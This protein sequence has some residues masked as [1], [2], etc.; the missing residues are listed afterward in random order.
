MNTVTWRDLLSRRFDTRDQAP[1]TTW[2][3]QRLGSVAAALAFRVGLSPNAV[4]LCGL[5]SMLAAALVYALGGSAGAWVLAAVLWQLGF[6]LD[7]ADGQLARAT[8]R[9]SAYGAWLDVACDHV[10]QSAI[11]LAVL[12]VL[13]TAGLPIG[14]AY[15]AVFAMLSG[16]TVYLHTAS[17]MKAEAPPAIRVG[18]W[19]TLVRQ[20]LRALLDTPFFLLLLCALRPQPSLLAL[21]AL[22]YGG[23]LVVRAL[24]I[25]ALRLQG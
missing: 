10:R 6:A 2:V 7:C 11:A 15:G 21:F 14:L 19:R 20:L 16:M 9:G 23:L 5:V 22:A 3:S 13:L 17:F 25:A 18:S 24:A 1:M 12:Y 4:T 8:G